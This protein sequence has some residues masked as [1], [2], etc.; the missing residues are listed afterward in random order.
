MKSIIVCL[1]LLLVPTLAN[2][3]LDFGAYYTR[4]NTGQEWE[5]YS[6]TGE[7]A[8]ITVQISDAGGKLV[9]WRGNSYLPYWKSDKGQWDLTEIIPRSGDGTKSM[10]DKVNAYSHA[11]II[12]NTPGVVVIHWRYLSSF[13]PGNPHGN[14]NPNNFAD[15]VFTI[16]PDGQVKRVV[17]KGT[18][19]IDDWND[20]LN[21]TTQLLKLNKEGVTEISRTNPGHS[22]SIIRLKGNP[23]KGPAVVPPSLWFSFDE[24]VGDNTKEKI[25]KTNSLVP[26]HKTH[27]KKGISG[28]ALEFDGYN[29]VVTVPAAKAPAVSGGSLTLEGWFALGAYPWNWAPIVQ[30]GDDDGYFLGVDSHGYPGFMVKAD[31]VWQQLTVPN[32]PPYTDANHISLFRW[33]HIAGT[34]QKNDGV[35]SLYLNG[36]EIASKVIGKGGVQTVNADVRVGKAKTM[37]KPTEDTHD[38]YPCEFTI[39][40]LIDE[41]KIYNI[42]LSKSQVSASYTNFNPGTEVINMPDMQRRKFPTLSTDGQFKAVYTRL[43]YYETWENLFRF[44]DYADVVVGFDNL[45]T[46]F[47]FW[48]GVSYIPM[49]VNDASQWFTNEFNETGGTEDAPGDNEPMSDKGS[50]DSHARVIENNGARVVVNWRYRLTEPGHHWANYN[51]TTGWGD[52]ADWEY[53]IYPDGVAS[54]IMRCY[55]SKADTWH[56]WDEQIV[57]L[58]EGQHPENVVRKAPVMTF[59][60][61]TGKA[62]DYDWN[63]NPP[64]PKFDG[65]MIQ[66][67]YFTGQ[68]NPYTIQNFTRGDIYN[69]EVTWYSVFPSW[70]HWPTS[71]INSSGRNSSFTDRSA[72]SSFSHLIW[73]YSSQ[74]R[75]KIPFDEKILME[76]MTNQPVT[77]L[78]SLAKSWLKAPVAVNVSGGTSQGYNLA[79][80]AY[81]F[82]F[83]TA[84]LSFM[85]AASDNNPIHNLCF[86]IRNWKSRTTFAELIINGVSQVPGKDF[87]QGINIDTD[88]TFTMIIWVGMKATSSQSF[89]VKM[90]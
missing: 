10:P 28:T 56:E 37:R 86:E 72:H 67:I 9:F 79:R 21:Q 2:G 60:D 52:I 39:D 65:Q 15:E 46:K 43:P 24:G 29:T 90:R 89:E 71:Q 64:N 48:R 68:Y 69:G 78:T 7:R 55:S 61:T 41:V 8:D 62:T 74:Q 34:Y 3:Q 11:E 76:G 30:Q 53:Y 23:E 81:C 85:I 4:L 16:T 51:D 25:T 27:W 31:N 50:Y 75:G 35:M 77:T 83:G 49:M 5:A 47:V 1:S 70:N 80:R 59:V 32:A 42:A 36:K 38:T 40:G 54:K 82:T 57:V 44:G 58:S 19:K 88:G 12:E 63:P 73:P 45:P 20:P 13:E 66:M 22:V 14:L 26:G 18:D 87:R 84:P 17:K 33:Y 6:R